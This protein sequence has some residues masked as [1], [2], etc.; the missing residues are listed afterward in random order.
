MPGSIVALSEKS[1]KRS[2]EDLVRQNIENMLNCRSRRKPTMLVGLERYERTAGRKAYQVGQGDCRN[3]R[4]ILD[5]PYPSSLCF[6][7]ESFPLT[8]C[9]NDGSKGHFRMRSSTV[10][11]LATS[12]KNSSRL[13]YGFT[14]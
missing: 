2:L 8:F 4:K 9:L 3:V 1:L 6:S 7:P 10:M 12:A 14:L 13:A 11:L 5:V